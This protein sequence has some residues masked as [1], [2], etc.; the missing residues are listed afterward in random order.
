MSWVSSFSRTLDCQSRG[1]GGR[2]LTQGHQLPNG[3]A[4]C[5]NSYGNACKAFK[6][7]CKSC[8]GFSLFFSSSIVERWAVNLQAEER[9]LP[10]EP[11][12]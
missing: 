6:S 7:R 8:R 10:K 5:Q 3:K 2:A 11:H 12:K 9:N 4:V 1:G